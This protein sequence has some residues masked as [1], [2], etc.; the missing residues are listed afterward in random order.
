VEKDEA[1]FQH[2]VGG[3]RLGGYFAPV[4]A[5]DAV[6]PGPEEGFDGKACGGDGGVDRFD[7]ETRTPRKLP[8]VRMEPAASSQCLAASVAR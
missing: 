6:G 8:G 1:E 5:A 2:G 3:I 7:A 4:A